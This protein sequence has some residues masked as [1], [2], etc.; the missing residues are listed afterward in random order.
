[1][2]Q[3]KNILVIIG[4]ASQHSANQQLMDRFT[5]LVKDEFNLRMFN[6]LKT[7]PHFDPELSIQ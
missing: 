1:M 6:D 3:K 2:K 7:L 4:S 5:D